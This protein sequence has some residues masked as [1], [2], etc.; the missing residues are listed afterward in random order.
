MSLIRMITSLSL[1]LCQDL[2][3]FPKIPRKAL[4]LQL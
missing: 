3:S 2:N 1:I 4:L